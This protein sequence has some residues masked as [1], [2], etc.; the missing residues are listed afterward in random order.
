MAESIAADYLVIG[1]GAMGMAFVDTLLSETTDKKIIMLDRRARPGGHWLVA[2][3]FVRLHQPAAFYGVNSRP[4]DNGAIDQVGWNKGLSELSSRDAVVSYFDLVMME[5][6]L[7]SGRVEFFPKHEYV[8]EGEFRS[9]LT[10]KS[11]KVGAETTIVDATYSRTSVPSMRPPPYEVAK[12]VDLVTPNGLPDITR[13]YA[14]YTVVG[15]GKTGID[16]CLWLLENDIK[17]SEITW[18]MP[19]DSFYLER[20]SFQPAS[21]DPEKALARLQ[22]TWQST[23]AATSVDHFLQ[24]QLDHHLLHRLNETVWPTMYHCA[25]VSLLELDAI[26]KIPTIIRKGRITKISPEKVSL[27]NGSYIPNP[28]TLYIDCSASAIAKTPPI[29]I[30]QTKKITLQPIRFC[31]QT[32][33]AALI[34][35]IEATT[36]PPCSSLEKKNSLAKP[37]PM[38]NDAID[39]VLVSLQSNLNQLAWG[40]ESSIRKFLKNSRLDYFGNIFPQPAPEGAM[41]FARRMGEQMVMMSRKLWGLLEG[42]SSLSCA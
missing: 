22:A 16:T 13:G 3:P 18:I 27:Q 41:E 40:G 4:L 39:N 33:S 15:A 36:Y 17:P 23:M 24:L 28:D 2:Y 1:A 7:P 19:R 31:Q 37:I 14:N 21:R 35:H 34:A 10:K 32:F 8:G 12:G 5:T 29:P 20:E 38:P 11:Y 26:R 25:S 6:F 30:F 42:F 9:L